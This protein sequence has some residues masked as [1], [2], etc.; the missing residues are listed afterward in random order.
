MTPQMLTSYSL[1][2]YLRWW[3]LEN[4]GTWLI[5]DTHGNLRFPVTLADG[6]IIY[7]TFNV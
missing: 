2:F 4:R 3:S 7:R 1:F 6:T 5:V